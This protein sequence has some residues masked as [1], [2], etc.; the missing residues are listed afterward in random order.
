MVPRVLFERFGGFDRQY[1]PAYYEDTDLAFKIRDAGH[2]V[3]YQPLSKVVH[4]EGLTHGRTAQ[5]G[6]SRINS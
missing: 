5:S 4:H 1:T 6:S 2:K 3:I